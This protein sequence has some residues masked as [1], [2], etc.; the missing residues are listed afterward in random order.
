MVAVQ[1]ATCRQTEKVVTTLCVSGGTK[2]ESSNRASLHAVIV[3][4]VCLDVLSEL[5][6]DVI[7]VVDGG[8]D[9]NCSWAHRRG[10]AALCR[11]TVQPKAAIV[12]EFDDHTSR[13]GFKRQHVDNAACTFLN[14]ADMTLDLGDVFVRGNGVQ[15]DADC[16]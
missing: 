13:N 1:S 3:W 4:F 10:D 9:N 16:R 2:G 7:V 11:K 12:Y 15:S 14:D 8:T 5:E 6:L